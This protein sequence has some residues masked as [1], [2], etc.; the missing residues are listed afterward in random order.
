MKKATLITTPLLISV[1]GVACAQDA[2][3]HPFSLRGGFSYLSN[4]DS[5]DAT[6]NSGW[7]IGG[8]Y[9]LSGKYMAGMGGNNAKVSIDV[10]FDSHRGNGNTIESGALQIA[11]RSSMTSGMGKGMGAPYFGASIG[12]F[13]NHISA[14]TTVS[15][16]VT[17]NSDTKTSLGGSVLVG[18]NF[19][20]NAFL[21]VSYRFSGSVDGV[22]CDTINAAIGIHF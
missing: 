22:R 6:N 10:D 20:Q 16:V 5:R 11:I 17:S 21:E 9:D 1:A 3:I 18:F 2:N 14:S 4:K 7:T 12:A 15:S 19:A 8:S 13:R